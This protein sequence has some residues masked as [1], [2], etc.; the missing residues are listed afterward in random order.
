MKNVFK[1]FGLIALIAVIGF[2]MAACGGDDGGGGGGG[3]KW[4]PA[5]GEY[6]Q[7]FTGILSNGNTT[8]IINWWGGGEAP[9]DP[10][11][12]S[13]GSL[14]GVWYR[15]DQSKSGRLTIS[16][17]NWTFAVKGIDADVPPAVHVARD[18]NGGE[19]IISTN[20]FVDI[21]KGTLTVNGTTITFI[22]THLNGD[23]E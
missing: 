18:N 8:L 22:T 3:G 19:P 9:F 1:L 15:T 16:G 5:T 7:P 17:T 2:S 10:F 12:K 23:V 13:G 11:T 14:N 4:I 6:T 20:D 21:A